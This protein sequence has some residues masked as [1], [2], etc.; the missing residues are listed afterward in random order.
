M[1]K[2]VYQAIASAL[3]S[4]NWAQE[5]NL[6]MADIWSDRIEELC[7]NCLPSGSGIDC[8]TT[9]D[10]DKSSPDKLVFNVS[11]HHMDEWGGY[12]GWTEHQVIVTPSLW[13]GMELRIMGRNERDIKEYLADTYREAL[14]AYAPAF[15]M[16]VAA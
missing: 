16:G 5:N 9:L 4:R 8:G 15:K 12:D 3:L 2:M 1:D 6:P 13:A 11:F 7:K 10:M 14:T